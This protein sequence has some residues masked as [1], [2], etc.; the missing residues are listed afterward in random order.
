MKC[1]SVYIMDKH[2]TQQINAIWTKDISYCYQGT[3]AN[4]LFTESADIFWNTCILKHCW[5][6]RISSSD[7]LPMGTYAGPAAVDGAVILL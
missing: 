2:P 3:Y 1:S 7:F 4:G 5:C 6:Y